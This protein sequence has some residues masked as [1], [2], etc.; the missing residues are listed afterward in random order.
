[1][2]VLPAGHGGKIVNLMVED[3]RAVELKRL[4]RDFESITLTAAAVYDL[5]LLMN[6]AFSPLTGFMGQDDYESVLSRMH[7]QNGWLWPLPVCLPV[8]ADRVQ[9][10]SPGQTVALRDPEGFMLAVLHIQD[11][12]PGDRE[13]EAQMV[14]GTGD[15]RHPGVR[16]LMASGAGFYVG[17]KVEGIQVPVHA[18]FKSLRHT[19]LEMR[20]RFKKLGWRRIVGY[21]PQSLLHR[22]E[23]E[24]T[25]RVMAHAKACLLLQPA[26]TT[27]ARGSV[28]NH[29]RIH[30]YIAA[31]KNYPA[32]M[33]QMNLL[34]FAMR[35]AGPREALLQA[36][37][38]KNYGCTHMI[39]APRHA[40][41]KPDDDEGLFYEEAAA[42]EMAISFCQELGIE[43][44]ACEPMQYVVEDDVY[45]PV[46]EVPA[47]VQTRQVDNDAF[48]DKL[49]NGRKIPEWVTFPEVVDI[50]HQAYPPRHQQGF[51][52][53]FTGLSGAGKSTIARI[54]SA[55][56]LEMRSRP[57]T[58]LDGD[59]V[60]RNLSSE[61]GFSKEHR[62]L[63]VKRIVFVA[64]E[65]TKNRGIAICAPIAPYGVTRKYVRRLIEQYGG[66]IEI[67]VGTP[68][69]ICESRDRKGLYA[70]ARAGLI[71][72]F[73]G[74]SDPY[75]A[76][77]SPEVYIDTTDMT[78]DEAVQEVLLYL[79]RSGYMR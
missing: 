14:F 61:L 30:C 5:E 22:A 38:Q 41:P 4:S 67:Y 71:R 43:I 48:H 68:L 63:N 53:F 52:L 28:D 16:R 45:L 23:F 76:P 79:E 75:E 50:I 37:I 60:R 73:T 29:T 36:I 72:E 70:K 32:N 62:D 40:S 58:L 7:L 26:V 10:L 33:M 57:V 9:S 24:M 69:D 59:I 64:S 20:Q 8:G 55:R 46:S 3:D 25:L 49:R 15:I 21:Q 54:L 35:M 19:P 44:V 65:I 77:E 31:G 11:I 42:A 12:W 2:N 74:I 6:G 27:I 56:L 17:G 39:V 47:G 66:F 51:T 1:M 18:A 34:P 78:P 13:R